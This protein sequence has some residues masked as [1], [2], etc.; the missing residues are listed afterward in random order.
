MYGQMKFTVYLKV[1]FGIGFWRCFIHSLTDYNFSNIISSKYQLYTI[2]TGVLK[3]YF[4]VEGTRNVDV[5]SM[6]HNH[7][8][9]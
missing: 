7:R 8:W 2:S 6:I 5:Q 3:M 9:L 4:W 1:N